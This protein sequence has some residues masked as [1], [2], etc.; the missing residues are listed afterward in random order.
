MSGRRQAR[1]RSH[2]RTPPRASRRSIAPC[3]RCR[4]S[5]RICSRPPS[6]AYGATRSRRSARICAAGWCCRARPATAGA[7]ERFE[8]SFG[9]QL[10]A[11]HDPH[12]VPDPVVVDGRFVLR[13]SIDLVER[14]T[15]SRVL[16]VTDHKTGK[17]RT[18]VTTTING[19]RTLQP[20]LYSLVVEEMTREPVD[21]RPSLLLH[22]GRRLHQPHRAARP[23]RTQ[24][25]PSRARGDRPRRGARVPRG[26]P[27]HRRLRL[28]RLP[29]GVRPV[30][31]EARDEEE[32][33]PP[34]RPAR[35]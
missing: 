18:A 5:R 8:L 29:P 28:L 4:S 19:G 20:V 35:L 31:G 30:R 16:R 12:S 6:I 22:A 9:L 10:D 32:Q 24:D 21:S 13:G 2:A 33:G 1:C 3:R 25:R 15:T 27:R 34:R 23:D 26:L 14:H 11:D 7:P 17:N